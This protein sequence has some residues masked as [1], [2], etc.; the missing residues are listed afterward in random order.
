MLNT[1]KYDLVQ[2]IFTFNDVWTPDDTV[3]S[4]IPSP[5]HVKLPST[6]NPAKSVQHLEPACTLNLLRLNYVSSQKPITSSDH[7][8]STKSNQL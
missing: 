4:T 6:F 5:Q 7:G 2:S 8:G 1:I 3:D